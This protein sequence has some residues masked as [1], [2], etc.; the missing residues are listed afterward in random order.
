M[1]FSWERFA[2]SR[3]ILLRRPAIG[4]NQDVRSSR[5][6]GFYKLSLEARVALIADWAELTGDETALLADSIGIEQADMMI[7]NV[8][9]RFAMPLGLGANFRINGP[10]LSGS[11]WR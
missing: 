3:G 11:R 2:Q 1:R 4:F 8:V 9:G 5:L 6:K 10:G 7:E